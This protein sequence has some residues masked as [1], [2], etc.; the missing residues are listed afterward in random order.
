MTHVYWI[1]RASNRVLSPP[2]QRRNIPVSVFS[3]AKLDTKRPAPAP[4]AFNYESQHQTLY[5]SRPSA[6]DN[7]YTTETYD[8]DMHRKIS[9]TNSN[10][11][12]TPTGLHTNEYSLSTSEKHDHG[13][14]MNVF[15]RLFRG[16]KKKSTN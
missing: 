12:K 14:K 5:S 2:G 16:N 15:E 13:K 4:P 11:S 1:S 10:G 8:D 7:E 9:S 3:P 6:V